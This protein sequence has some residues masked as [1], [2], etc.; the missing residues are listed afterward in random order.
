M[1]KKFMNKKATEMTIGD[2][3]LYCGIYSGLCV[4]VWGFIVGLCNLASFIKKLK[5]K[6]EPI[7]VE[8]IEV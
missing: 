4:A 6:K 8:E 3:M 5:K 2:T 7:E 1:I